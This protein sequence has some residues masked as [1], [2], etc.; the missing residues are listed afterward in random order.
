MIGDQAPAERLNFPSLLAARREDQ[1]Q[2]EEVIPTF[3][4]L[5]TEAARILVMIGCFP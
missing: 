1:T 3:V 2:A 5:G 4:I